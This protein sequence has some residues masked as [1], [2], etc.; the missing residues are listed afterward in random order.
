M[1][2]YERQL[3][4]FEAKYKASFPQMEKRIKAEKKENFELWDD[5]IVWKGLYEAYN[6]WRKRYQEF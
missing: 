6:K 2:E 3:Q 4:I 1:K 5:Y